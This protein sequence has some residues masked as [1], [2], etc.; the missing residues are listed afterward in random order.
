M[1]NSIHRKQACRLIFTPPTPPLLHPA[2]LIE[3]RAQLTRAIGC[4]L[5]RLGKRMMCGALT[6][7][8]ISR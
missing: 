3:E 2:P 6:V 4:P 1:S 5:I 8:R 7:G